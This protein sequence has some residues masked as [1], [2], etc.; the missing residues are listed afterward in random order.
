MTADW[1]AALRNAEALRST[2]DVAPSLVGAR[3]AELHL[4]HHGLR[5][6]FDPPLPPERV[7]HHG[8]LIHP[9][10][11]E[12]FTDADLS[13]LSPAFSNQSGSGS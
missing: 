6:V 13:R 5:L 8:R 12:G 11:A 1:Y 10:D 4:D 2:W 3:M 9:Q 7:A